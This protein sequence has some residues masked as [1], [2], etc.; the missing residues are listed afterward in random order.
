M[1]ETRIKTALGE[2]DAIVG[3]Q[4]ARVQID[5]ASDP[6]WVVIRANDA[7]Y[8]RLGVALAR[9][10][11]A[12]RCRGGY[13]WHSIAFGLPAFV[14]TP[15][16]VQFLRLDDMPEYARRRAP[17]KWVRAFLNATI[18]ILALSGLLHLVTMAF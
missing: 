1:D 12:E 4:D 18:W 16:Q 10:A 15:G 3:D 13:D 5:C 14:E 8:V 11:Y 6:D 9:A 17:R 7:G 2:L